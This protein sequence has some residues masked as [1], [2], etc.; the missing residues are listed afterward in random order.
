M[1]GGGGWPM[2][3]FL[4]PDGRPFFGGT[5]FPPEPH[6]GLPSFRQVLAGAARAWRDDRLQVVAAGQ[7]LAETLAEQNRLA[8]DG[9]APTEALL[10]DAEVALQARFD[11]LN[12]SWGGAPKFPQPM[13]I[14]FLLAR[15]AAGVG[16]SAAMVRYTLDRMADGGIHD[17]LGGG[18]HRYATDPIWLV[19]HFEQMLYDNAQLARTYLRAWAQLPGRDRPGI[20][21]YRGVATGIL[22][23]LLRELRRDDGTF[24]ASQDADTDGVEGATFTWTADELRAA[25]GDRFAEFAA[26]YGVRDEGN[27]E[28]RT[29]LSRIQPA[30]DES[31]AIDAER[32]ARLAADR[33]RLLAVRRARPQPARDDKAL[34]AWNGL[35]IGA[36]A[37]AW[38][39]LA[40]DDAP[41]ADRYLAAAIAAADAILAGLRRPDGRLGRSWKDGRASGEGVLEDYADLA[42]GLLALYAATFDERWF[43]TA[44]ELAEA[45]LGHFA[46]PSGGFFDTADDHEALVTRPKDPQDNATPSGGSM[47]ARVLLRLAA[48]TGERRYR[49]A[50][51]RALAT[52]T[53][54]L[55]RYPTGFG[56]WLSAAG[57]AVAGIVELA[58]VGEPADPATRALLAAALDDEPPNLVVA[59]SPAPDRSAIPLLA[60][61]TMID[62]R[63]TAYVCR[64]FACRLPVTEPAALVEQLRAAR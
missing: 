46:D 54:Y 12:G 56:N 50:A 57:L 2:S 61:R 62:G 25:L 18:F 8:T 38:R 3:V 59:V 26:V 39:L 11:T 17:Q 55:A 30:S 16:H 10:R 15:T 44:R 60:G 53:P 29:I 14:D 32:E 7:R 43:I 4:T 28:G 49:D 36:L 20:S 23:Y 22:D 40:D 48:L 34:A 19:P 37:D 63:P 13:T 24:A 5:Y 51:D 41:A 21:R 35:A 45:I 1:T 58:I 47:A 6:H 64:D 31:G 52:V 33:A 42:D 27:W 9:A